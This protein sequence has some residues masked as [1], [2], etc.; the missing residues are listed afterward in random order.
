MR[1]DKFRRIFILYDGLA[2]H[3]TPQ[4]LSMHPFP[5]SFSP[6]RFLS[7]SSVSLNLFPTRF[8]RL[9]WMEDPRPTQTSLSQAGGGIHAAGSRWMVDR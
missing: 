4:P 2:L 3:K 5:P 9:D 7:V 6:I 8:T 1:M